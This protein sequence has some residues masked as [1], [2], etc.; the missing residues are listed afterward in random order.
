MQIDLANF[1]GMPDGEFKFLLGISTALVSKRA[2]AIACMLL[3]IFSVFGPLAILQ[4][5]NGRE[6]VGVANLTKVD[7]SDEVSDLNLIL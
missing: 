7:I 4:S 2:S 3:E 5:D 6:F 1:Q